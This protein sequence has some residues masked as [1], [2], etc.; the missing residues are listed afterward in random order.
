MV[1]QKPLRLT[2]EIVY[3]YIS[4]LGNIHG[5][6]TDLLR[7]FDQGGFP[8]QTSYLFLGDYVNY[9]HQSLGTICL[10]LAFKVCSFLQTKF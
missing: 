9:G 3:I 8:P 10:L 5:H 4:I 6:Y 7:H 2:I 1:K